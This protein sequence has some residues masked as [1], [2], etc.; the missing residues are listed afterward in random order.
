M[1]HHSERVYNFSA[2]PAVLPKVVLERIAS[3]MISLPGVGSSILEVS[4]RGK[5]FTEY[6][7]RA[8]DGLRNTLKVPDEYEILFLQG[9][10]R[11]QFAMLPMNFLRGTQKKAAYAVTGSWGKQA[12]AEAERL[13]KAE[14]VWS[15]EDQGFVDLPTAPFQLDAND[16]SYFYYVSNET[17]QGLQFPGEPQAGDVPLICDASSDFLHK[18]I[19]IN[20]YGIIYA[21][22]QKNAGPAG[23]TIVIIR[24]EMIPSGNSDLPGYLDYHAHAA[25][26]SLFNTPPTFAI[27]VFALV[28]EWLNGEAGGLERMYELNH[29]KAKLLYDVIDRFQGVYRGHAKAECR[30]VMNV[31]FNF[32]DESLKEKFLMGAETAGLTSLA[33]HRSVGGIR[34]SIYNAMPL[35]GVEKL[36]D[37]MF[38][39]AESNG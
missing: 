17:I 11:L 29:R 24:K 39:F 18:P 37:Y 9:G 31:V 19:D 14:C 20:R 34:A 15:G 10:S 22:A 35:E 38:D 7:N 21:C 13:G 23:L 27:Y 5:V 4:H 36:A 16:Y 2:G 8:R 30:S 1:H 28:I 6:L 25:N 33:G 26:G 12:L 3:E 32:L